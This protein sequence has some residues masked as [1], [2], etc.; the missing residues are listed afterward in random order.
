MRLTDFATSP[1]KFPS[2]L[3]GLSFTGSPAE[4]IKAFRPVRPGLA[5]DTY[6]YKATFEPPKPRRSTGEARI[7]A[8]VKHT[9]DKQE[10]NIEMA[11]NWLIRWTATDSDLPFAFMRAYHR[12]LSNYLP[13]Y[14]PDIN[15]AISTSQLVGAPGYIFIAGT[16]LE[17][18]D[19][20]I[21][22]KLR[23]VT[24][25]GFLASSALPSSH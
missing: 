8:H 20:L 14:Q 2:H 3:D 24:T 21:H 15:E 1:G 17:V 13:L 18:C 12:Q 19:A 16:L 10:I 4:Y 11:G 25:V 22:R 9:G 7:D 5:G 23:S 6:L